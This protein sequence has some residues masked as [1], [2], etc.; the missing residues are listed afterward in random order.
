[1]N[2][3]EFLGGNFEFNKICKKNGITFSQILG[4]KETISRPQNGGKKKETG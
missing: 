1:M 3:L 4:K 2:K